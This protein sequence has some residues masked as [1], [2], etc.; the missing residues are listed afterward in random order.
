MTISRESAG[1]K[2][3]GGTGV[4]LRVPLRGTVW[5]EGRG[6]R[7]RSRSWLLLLLLPL[8]LQLQLPLP[9]PFRSR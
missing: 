5:R 1:G 4:G 6:G 2:K 8:Q 9:L 3:F 7:G